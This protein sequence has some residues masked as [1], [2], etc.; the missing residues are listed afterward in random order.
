MRIDL[1]VDEPFD[2]DEEHPAAYVLDL[3]PHLTAPFVRLDTLIAMKRKAGRPK[4]IA[5][6]A[7][8]QRELRDA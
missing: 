7:F 4:D 5:D 8:L 6:L 1:F 3:S 2:F